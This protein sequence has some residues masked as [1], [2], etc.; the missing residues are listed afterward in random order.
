MIAGNR[1]MPQEFSSAPMSHI[2]LL[3]SSILCIFSPIAAETV[4]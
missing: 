4:R 1:A 3:D 2:P